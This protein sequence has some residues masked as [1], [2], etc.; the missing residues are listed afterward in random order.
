MLIRKIVIKSEA[1]YKSNEESTARRIE[2]MM[3]W[4]LLYV[5]KFFYL[6]LE[7]KLKSYVIKVLSCC[8]VQDIQYI[9]G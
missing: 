4:F 3:S 5:R 2:S 6:M 7:K 9:V 1:S 8:S